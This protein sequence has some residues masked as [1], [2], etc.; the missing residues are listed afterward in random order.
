M[1][2]APRHR[3]GI[4]SKESPYLNI[5]N[6]NFSKIFLIKISCL[7]VDQMA[8]LSIKQFFKFLITQTN[9]V[10]QLGSML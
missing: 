6:C 8:G 3:L 2:T 5:P 1:S 4:K 10:V 9:Q 7:F